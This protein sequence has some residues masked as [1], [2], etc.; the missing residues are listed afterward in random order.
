MTVMEH[1][2]DGSETNSE[3]SV[4]QEDTDSEDT[5]N[6]DQPLPLLIQTFASYPDSPP[7]KWFS[8][9][10]PYFTRH[11]ISANQILWSQDECADAL[12]LI[13][14]GSL[15]ATYDH[16]H[17]HG[18]ER[19]GAGMLETMVAGTVAGDLSMLSGTKRNATVV[20]ER[21][22]VVW[23]LDQ[24]ALGRMEKEK[25]EVAR[26]FIKIVLKGECR[27]YLGYQI[28]MVLMNISCRRGT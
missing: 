16:G 6:E 25:P 26:E 15:R 17:G 3:V 4:Y 21:D 19:V 5:L 28:R 8:N 27:Y 18:D 23:R 7:L 9:L 10:V 11:P 13:E 22:G 12:Y 1:P 24:Q 20:A 14:I 2:K